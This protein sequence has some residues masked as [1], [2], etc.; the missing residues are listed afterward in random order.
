MAQHQYLS[1]RIGDAS[2]LL[3]G[4]ASLAIE[5]RAS[6]GPKK[7]G[8]IA[9]AWR[10]DKGGDWPAYALDSELRLASNGNWQRVVFVQGAPRP[11]GLAA[12]EIQLLADEEII[13][14][15]F[16]P[17]GDWIPGVGHLISSAWINEGEI[18]L[19]LD[20]AKLGAYLQMLGNR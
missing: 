19:V 20:P 8:D 4:A 17:L 6:L 5:K 9:V 14:E 16:T 12:E 3:H 15:P 13:P 2:F 7:E 18:N 11:V 1:I 10:A